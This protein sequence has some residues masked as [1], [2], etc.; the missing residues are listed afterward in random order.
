MSLCLAPP[1]F[2]TIYGS[3]GPRLL[4]RWALVVVGLPLSSETNYWS[5][6][7]R[8]GMLRD[9]DGSYAPV[10]GPRTARIGAVFALPQRELGLDP[11]D[12]RRFVRTYYAGVQR[13][14][15]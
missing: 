4:R 5:C 13:L 3:R 15:K 8:A 10:L 6:G 7:P 9:H 11:H 1:R 2:E 14:Q 12:T